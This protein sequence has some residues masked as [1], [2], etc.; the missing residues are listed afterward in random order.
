MKKY[1][2]LSNANLNFNPHLGESQVSGDQTKNFMVWEGFHLGKTNPS[3][4]SHLN[5]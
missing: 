1:L 2:K 4:F 5:L 3:L